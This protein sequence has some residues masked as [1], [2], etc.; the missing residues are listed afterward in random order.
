MP[1]RQVDGGVVRDGG[2]GGGGGG[3]GMTE[4]VFFVLMAIASG[5]L[6]LMSGVGMWGIRKLMLNSPI[7]ILPGILPG[8]SGSILVAQDGSQDGNCQ[9]DTEAAQKPAQQSDAHKSKLKKKKTKKT[10]TEAHN[11]RKAKHPYVPHVDPHVDSDSLSDDGE[12]VR[13]EGFVAL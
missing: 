7:S 6:L 5:V 4:H 11:R 3:A 12:E 9:D 8:R 13:D 1:S 10:K 2:G